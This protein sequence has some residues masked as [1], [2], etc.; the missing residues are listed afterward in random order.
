MSFQLR[1]IFFVDD[2]DI[3]ECIPA[4][5]GTPEKAWHVLYNLDSDNKL[6]GFNAN[7]TAI[8]VEYC[9]GTKINADQAYDRYCWVMA[10]I[11]Y[12]FNLDP[13]KSVVGH[14]FLDPQRKSD[15]VTGLAFSRRTYEQLLRDVAIMYKECL[16]EEPILTRIEEKHRVKSVGKLNLRKGKASTRADIVKTLVAGEELDVVA[17]VSDGEVVNGNSK[18]FITNENSYLWSGGVQI[19]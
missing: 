4:L 2:K 17:Y 13:A 18:W 7:D 12:T 3:I 16:G 1:H 9:Y 6:Y 5:T 14:F 19:L 11:C 8:G 15:P 10:Y